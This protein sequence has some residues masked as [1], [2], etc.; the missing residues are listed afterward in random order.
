MPPPF[1]RLPLFPLFPLLLLI[2]VSCET[3]DNSDSVSFE[4]IHRHHRD[5]SERIH[6]PATHLERLRELAHNDQ[7][8]HRWISMKLGRSPRR[9]ANEV[10]RSKDFLRMSMTSAAYAHGGSYFVIFNIGTPSQKFLMVADT[11]SDL[12]WMNC[13]Y[14]CQKCKPDRELINRRVFRADD[15]RTF[16][17]INCSSS[18]CMHL[19][20][21]RTTCPEP[22][23]P[24]Y[25]LY[26]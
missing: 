10:G 4:L 11:G 7:L 3:V 2:L 24:C 16:K 15:S 8:R 12:T 22:S 9:R 23:A 26:R 6:Q 17:L 5:L 14:K 13:R 1:L 20:R 25:Y 21:S 18:A 19:P